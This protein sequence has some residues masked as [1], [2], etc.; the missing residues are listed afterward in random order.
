[1]RLNPISSLSKPPKTRFVLGSNLNTKKQTMV[2][3][4]APSILWRQSYSK[5]VIVENFSTSSHVAS[6]SGQDIIRSC[7]PARVWS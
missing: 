7:T 5:W 1:M 2:F 4:M 6:K 3:R